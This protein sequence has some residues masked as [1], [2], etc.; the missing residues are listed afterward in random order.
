MSGEVSV[1]SRFVVKFV[2]IIAAGLATAASGYLIA[3]LSGALSSPAPV[4][5]RTVIQNAAKM[6]RSRILSASK[7]TR[8]PDG[9][10]A[11]IERF[12]SEP[13]DENGGG[14][15]VRLRKRHQKKS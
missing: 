13:I 10:L 5:A 1:F 12:S 4:P 2:E 11:N 6:K 7:R 3:H 8:L 14:P 15:G 9:G